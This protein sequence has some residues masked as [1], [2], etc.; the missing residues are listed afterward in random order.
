MWQ[1]GLAV[2]ALA[3]LATQV[4]E[5][6]DE[7]SGMDDVSVQFI[8]LHVPRGNAVEWAAAT[9]CGLLGKDVLLGLDN[10]TLTSTL[11]NAAVVYQ[12]RCPWAHAVKRHV[13]NKA[14]P[15]SS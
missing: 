5:R 9:L 14:M 4:R 10:S 11:Q 13:L 15:S 6:R 2:L 8:Q 1:C 3:G 12:Q 7:W